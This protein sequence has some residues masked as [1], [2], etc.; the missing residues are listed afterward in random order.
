ME[1]PEGKSKKQEDRENFNR[2]REAGWENV[3]Q[4]RSQ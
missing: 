1:L 4:K 3:V 2:M